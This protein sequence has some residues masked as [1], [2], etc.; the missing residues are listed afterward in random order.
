MGLMLTAK[1]INSVIKVEK[2]IVQS[3][4]QQLTISQN[5]IVMIVVVFNFL[6]KCYKTFF[7]RVLLISM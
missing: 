6:L 5:V 4:V 3:C 7:K 1:V 2:T